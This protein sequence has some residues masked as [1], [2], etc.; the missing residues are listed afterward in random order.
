MI[1]NLLRR[2][3]LKYVRV[4]LNQSLHPEEARNQ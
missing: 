4:E 3:N 1:T 2:V